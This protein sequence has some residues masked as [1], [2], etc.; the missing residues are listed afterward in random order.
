[1]AFTPTTVIDLAGSVIIT[2]Q[3]DR[4]TLLQLDCG[5]ISM[6][7]HERTP[8]VNTDFSTAPLT[9]PA[10]GELLSAV[11]WAHIEGES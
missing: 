6:T 9:R 3:R 1:V 11:A 10:C 8:S 7:F 5:T 4:R 2:A